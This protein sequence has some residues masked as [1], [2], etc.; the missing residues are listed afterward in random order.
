MKKRENISKTQ[1]HIRHGKKHISTRA[2]IL[3][4]A[5]VFAA[6]S[7]AGAVIVDGRHV[8]F[9]MSGPEDM[10][11]EYGESYTEPGIYAVTAGQLFGEGGTRLEVQSSGAPDTSRLGSYTVEYSAR[12]GLRD[13]YASRRVTVVDTT[14]PVIELIH[15]EGHAMT[16][17]TGYEE[18]GFTASDNHDGDIT[19]QV[20]RTEELNRIVYTVTDSSGNVATAERELVFAGGPPAIR[21]L[22]SAETVISAQ[23]FFTDPGFVATDDAGNDLSALVSVT[24]DIVPYRAGSYERVYSITNTLGEEVSVTRTVTVLPVDRPEA[25]TPEGKTIYLTFDDGP[26]P[27][28]AALLDLL[29]EYGV[30]ATFFVTSSDSRYADLIGR[31]YREGHSIGVHT[32]S[33]NYKAIYA[34]EQAFF[35]D[36]FAMEDVIFQQTG[37]YTDIFRFPGG[38]SNTVSS[39]N[40]GIMSRLTA[41]MTDMGYS[42]FD[43]NVSSGDAGETTKTDVVA[44]NVIDGC[45]GRKVSVVLQHDIKDYSVAAVE[46]IILWG[47]ENGYSFMALGPSSPV[48]HHSV[49][50]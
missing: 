22:G 23:R 19:A 24:G 43:W 18:E 45:A 10:T 37:S 28:T 4:V 47:Q 30:R 48:T 15:R 41:A 8:R 46:K 33:H 50:N 49:A 25:S 14:P 7:A 12:W 5:L 17:L 40:P 35:D 31:A 44:K 21:L 39:F 20:Q 27:Y 32:G 38:S 3:I 29:A 9:Y 26:G 6:L 11:V 42:Y 2:F 13:Y 1:H 36:F 34:S 16:W